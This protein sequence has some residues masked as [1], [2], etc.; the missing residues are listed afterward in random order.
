MTNG[1]FYKELRRQRDKWRTDRRSLC[2]FDRP[3]EAGYADGF[4]KSAL[5]R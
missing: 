2:G 4:R 5:K 3:C 1:D